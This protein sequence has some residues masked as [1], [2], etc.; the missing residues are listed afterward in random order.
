MVNVNERPVSTAAR[1]S[2][3]ANDPH[4]RL[5]KVVPRAVYRGEI[6]EIFVTDDPKAK[7]GGLMK[8]FSLVGHFEVEKGGFVR[9]GDYVSVGGHEL[10]PIVGYNACPA[11]R[12]PESAVIHMYVRGDKLVSGADLALKLDDEVVTRPVDP[13]AM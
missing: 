13:A 12:A 3:R 2:R 9:A 5:M 4:M 8:R 1:P 6:Y 7:P 10:G 11:L